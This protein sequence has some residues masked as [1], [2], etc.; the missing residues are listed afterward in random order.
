M[1]FPSSAF[2]AYS[3]GGVMF[4][5]QLPYAKLFSLLLYPSLAFSRVCSAARLSERVQG[6]TLGGT[7]LYCRVKLSGVGGA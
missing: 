3:V 7:L 6:A 2:V 4:G 5:E 1:S